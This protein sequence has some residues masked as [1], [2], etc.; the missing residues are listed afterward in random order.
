MSVALTNMLP[1][2]L[3]GVMVALTLIFLPHLHDDTPRRSDDPFAKDAQHHEP[4]P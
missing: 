1:V 4:R 3:L 2:V